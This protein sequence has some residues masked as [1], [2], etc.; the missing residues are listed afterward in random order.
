MDVCLHI[1]VLYVCVCVCVYGTTFVFP[2]RNN[3]LG[4]GVLIN[5]DDE[6]RYIIITVIYDRY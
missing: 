6:D 4:S 3:D 5:Y 1:V 2:F